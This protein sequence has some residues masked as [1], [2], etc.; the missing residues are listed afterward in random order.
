MSRR[1]TD[2]KGQLWGVVFPLLPSF[3]GGSPALV[4]SWL[5][6]GLDLSLSDAWCF[7]LRVEKSTGYTTRRLQV[8]LLRK[9][10][11]I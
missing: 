2:K 6:A 11:H 9:K 3:R 5:D 4:I 1:A 7:F 8:F 10:I